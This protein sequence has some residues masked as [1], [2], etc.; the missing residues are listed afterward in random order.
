MNAPPTSGLSR[1][2]P[3]SIRQP[4]AAGSAPDSTRRSS[5]CSACS[6]TAMHLPGSRCR[7][8]PASA[9]TSPP[10]L[11]PSGRIAGSAGSLAPGTTCSGCSGTSRRT[12]RSLRLPSRCHASRIARPSIEHSPPASTTSA[13][14]LE[15]RRLRRASMRPG[16]SLQPGRGELAG[17]Q[18][19][20]SVNRFMALTFVAA[21]GLVVAAPRSFGQARADDAPAQAA[22]TAPTSDDKHFVY[23]DFEKADDNKKPVSARGGEV[24]LNP[25][26]SQGSREATAQG[27]RARSRQEGR[28]EPP[29]EIRLRALRR[30]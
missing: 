20:T 21:A 7:T 22:A 9:S 24:I 26:Q 30:R 10:A 8:T 14:L 29:A 2:L 3:T 16:H 25:Y 19:E 15:P 1:S 4:I 23:A 12:S 28:S 27:S 13:A 17:F 18:E 5:P 11:S 6:A